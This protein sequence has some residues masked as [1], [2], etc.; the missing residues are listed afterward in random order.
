M[1]KNELYFKEKYIINKI[2]KEKGLV[3]ISYDSLEIVAEIETLK[4]IKGM[5][6]HKTKEVKNEN[7]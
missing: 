6:F 5:N 3:Y 7:I 1:K 2:D 4:S